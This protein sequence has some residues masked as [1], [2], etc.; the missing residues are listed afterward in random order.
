MNTSKLPP[1]QERLVILTGEES[2][3][4][5]YE[6]VCAYAMA[7][8]VR[9]YL[10]PS[11]APR[12]PKTQAGPPNHTNTSLPLEE[13]Q[14]QQQQQQAAAALERQRM[15]ER[16]KEDEQVAAGII[17]LSIDQSLRK[18]IKSSN[19]PWQMMDRLKERF[20]PRKQGVYSA[21]YKAWLTIHPTR[22]MGHESDNN[23]TMSLAEWGEVVSKGK[24]AMVGMGETLPEWAYIYAF[25]RGLSGGEFA[26]YV[27]DLLHMLDQRAEEL[28]DKNNNDEDADYYDSEISFEEVFESFLQ[29]EREVKKAKA[30]ENEKRNKKT[31][32]RVEPQATQPPPAWSVRV[33]FFDDDGRR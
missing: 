31:Q 20:G 6:T 25:M 19:T 11:S 3:D 10:D 13:Q 12:L 7:N 15:L 4:A 17:M 14:Q 26:A 21:R 30:A 2:Y 27:D 22:T 32:K 24:G 16:N 28:K 8:R 29:H 5:W 18:L 33:S 1:L 9:K 23:S